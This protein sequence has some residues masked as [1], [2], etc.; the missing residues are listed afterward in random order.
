MMVLLIT[1]ACGAFAPT[2]SYN[3]WEVVS[4]PIDATVSD[5]SFVSNDS[6]HGWLVG[7]HSSLLETFD[8]GKSWELRELALDEQ[9]YRFTSVSFSGQ[10]GWITGKPSILLHTADGGKSWSRIA[11]SARLPGSPNTVVAVGP[12]SAEMTTDVGAIYQTTDGGKTWKALVEQ[13]VGVLR[14]IARSAD[15]KY[16][17]VSA[18]GNFYSTWEPGQTAW[19]PHNRNRSRRVQNMGFTQDD[20]LWMLS[21][22]GSL[23][24][25]EPDQPEEWGEP[26][27]P[28]VA[29]SVGLLDLAYRTPEEVWLAGG[30][31]NL[32]C[33]LDGGKTWQKDEAIESVPSNL[34]KILFVKPEQGFII[35]Q[36]GTLLRYYTGPQK[37][38]EA[39]PTHST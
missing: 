33:S 25:S 19:T 4:L 10:E 5:I 35:G 21:R 38:A 7:N 12:Q 14:N 36:K 16:V 1:T 39:E 28:Q 6:L 18:R 23:Q 8:G 22:G 32:L 13:A 20:R 2:L 11:L 17:A 24:F 37:S 3:P 34:Y 30:S 15:G 26:Q 27:N 9:D 31:G 29:V